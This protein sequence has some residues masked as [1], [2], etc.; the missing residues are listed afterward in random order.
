MITIACLVQAF[1]CC[2]LQCL[3]L[4]VSFTQAQV[5]QYGDVQAF[6]S[7]GSFV[8]CFE[9]QSLNLADILVSDVI[10]I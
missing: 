8:Y 5:L 6:T 4:Y 7:R 2:S 10:I 9:H 3:P 1:S